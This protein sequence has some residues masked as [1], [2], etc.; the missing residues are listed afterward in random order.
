MCVRWFQFLSMDIFK[1]MFA[2]IGENGQGIGT[3]SF[4]HWVKNVAALNLSTD[5]K[6]AVDGLID[7]CYAQLD[8]G[9]YPKIE[10]V[11]WASYVPVDLSCLDFPQT[12]DD[13]IDIESALTSF[14]G[15]VLGA[16]TW[17]WF[18]FLFYSHH[19]LNQ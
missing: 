6:F 4:G 9:K 14:T 17:N 2:L 7:E 15:L 10:C 12:A 18:W 16:K 19:G 1:R 5:E 13:V 11:F 8:E 3:S